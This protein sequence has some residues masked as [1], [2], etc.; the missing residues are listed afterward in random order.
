MILKLHGHLSAVSVCLL[1]LA[2][3][4]IAFIGGSL[5]CV[6]DSSTPYLMPFKAFKEVLKNLQHCV[7]TVRKQLL[8]M[9]RVN[10]LKFFLQQ[11][12]RI[13]ANK[14]LSIGCS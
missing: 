6:I 3:D 14:R 12:R 7:A 11:L 9:I 1:V 2:F 4:T 10:V 8:T 13:A 5:R